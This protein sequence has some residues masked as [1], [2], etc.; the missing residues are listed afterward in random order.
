M[1][2]I[3]TTGSQQVIDEL[4]KRAL[5]AAPIAEA[6]VNVGA[7]QYRDA[8]REVAENHGFR[9]TGAMIASITTLPKAE[10]Y[11]GSYSQVISPRGK[12]GKGVRNGEKAF[13][14]HYGTSSIRPSYWV[15]EADAL[16]EPRAIAAQD[17]VWNNYD[18]TGEI[19]EVA[20]DG[21]VTPGGSGRS[22]RKKKADGW[23]DKHVREHR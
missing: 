1:G 12:D 10:I 17:A 21:P 9:K 3:T 22:G 8:W 4:R 18:Q 13:I 7:I 20:L 5:E 23:R 15:E 6:L 2:R 16:A 19:P 14:L 11:G